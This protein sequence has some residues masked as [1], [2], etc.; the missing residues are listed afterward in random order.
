MTQPATILPLIHAGATLFM[1]GLIWFVQIVHY[2][3][4]AEVGVVGFARYEQ[5]HSARTTL[6]VA[7]VML[8]ELASAVAL[9]VIPGSLP[10]W[11]TLAGAA[12]VA[13]IWLST[14]FLSVPRHSELAA[15]FLPEAHRSLVLTNWIR[16]AAWTLRAVLALGMLARPARL[17]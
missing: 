17:I 5:L 16:T 10:R 3:L 7:P 1:T 2:P 8:I 13:V 12:L 15:G 11:M 4:F 9:L 6:I 14:F